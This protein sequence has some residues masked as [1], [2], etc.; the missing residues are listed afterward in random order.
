MALK[1]ERV[2]GKSI[3]LDGDRAVAEAVRQMNPDVVAAYPITPQTEIVQ[4]FSEFVANG[5]VDTE[6][7]PVESE[8]AAMSV[9]IGASAAGG[10]AQTATAGA[11][12]AFMW[13]MLWIASG[14]RLPIVMHVV[15]R[16]LSAPLNILCDHSDSMGARDAGWVQLYGENVQEAYDNAIQAVRIAEHPDVMLPTLHGLDGFIIGHGVERLE[17]LPDEAVRQFIGTYNPEHSL[18]D[19]DHPVTYGPNDYHDYF[20]EH[21]RQQV[22]GMEKALEVVPVIG[23][24][25]GRLTGRYYGLMEQYRLEDAEFAT[26][27]LGSMVGTTKVVVDE[28]RDQGIKAGLL[29]LRCFRPFPAAAVAQALGDKKAIAVLDRSLSF[30]AQG[31]QLF[32]EVCTALFTHGYAPKVVNYVYGLG[33]RDTVPA[34]IRQ[35]Y[36]DLAQIDGDGKVEPVLRYL[37]VRE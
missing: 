30:G 14:T 10:R 25:Y 20:F 13:E 29:K 26:V 4:R 11:G 12:L 8:H 27:A 15:N 31:N 35:V 18:L 34:Q 2:K 22:A 17:L 1:L 28:L 19:V 9:C 24:E 32:L 21:K 6:F 16:S 3:A 37:S 33:G 36:R 23:E 5:E 7:V